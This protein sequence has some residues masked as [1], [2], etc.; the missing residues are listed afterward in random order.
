MLNRY[1]VVGLFWVGL[2]ASPALASPVGWTPSHIVT[3]IEENHGYNDIIG[4]PNAPYINNLANQN[5]SFTNSHGVEHPSQPNYLDIYSG[6]NQGWAGTDSPVP[7]T[8]LSTPN[9]GAS[10]ISKGY[11]FA[12]YSEDQPGVGSLAISANNNNYARKHN[13]WSNWQ[14]SN[15]GP[16]QLPASTNQPFSA[17]PTD[18]NQLPT[19]SFVIPNQSDDMHGISGGLTG[20][21][22]IAQ[23]DAWLQNN[24]NAYLDWAKAN[25]SLLIVTFDEDDFT[26]ENRIPTIFAGANVK[27]GQY[28]ELID[29]FSI[30][31]TIEEMY[32][33][34]P[35]GASAAATSIT[36]AFNAPAP[37]PVPPALTLLGSALAA[38]GVLRRRKAESAS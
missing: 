2:I 4:N 5:A 16:N 23:G 31:K 10:L 27:P 28:N 30:L 6:S 12:G 38:L 3:V 7:N 18:F 13:P 9:L 21:A 33:L 26:P 36:D 37:V 1:R 32:G 22:L 19:V 17:F 35:A 34:D 11:G 29:H 14:A 24:I 25:N 20:D 15:P 8:P